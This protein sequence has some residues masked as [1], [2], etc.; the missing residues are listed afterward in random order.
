MTNESF[1][2]LTCLLHGRIGC[3]NGSILYKFSGVVGIKVCAGNF[4]IWGNP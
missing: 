4:V 2:V 3:A 1:V